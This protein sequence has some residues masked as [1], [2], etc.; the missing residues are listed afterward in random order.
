MVLS[1]GLIVLPTNVQ[2][3]ATPTNPARLVAEPVVTL[4]AALSVDLAT[5]SAWLVGS[6]C[7]SIVEPTE[8][9]DP[10]H[11]RGS[12]VQSSVI[13]ACLLGQKPP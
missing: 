11:I 2:G 6:V 3:S 5:T 8:V 1:V 12:P 4:P 10:R 13:G 9:S 7:A